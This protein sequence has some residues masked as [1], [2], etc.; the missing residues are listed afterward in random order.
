MPPSKRVLFLVRAMPKSMITVRP[1]RDSMMFSGFRAQ[2]GGLR[3]LWAGKKPK[4][5][6]LGRIAAFDPT[7]CVG[8][9]VATTGANPGD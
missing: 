5:N 2:G 4:G 8:A 7:D 1:A 3:R 9:E 6:L